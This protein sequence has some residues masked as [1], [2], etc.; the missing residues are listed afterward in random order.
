MEWI[1]ILGP[2]IHITKD[3][4][5]GRLGYDTYT[6]LEMYGAVFPKFEGARTE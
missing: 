1:N 6:Q 3:E 4:E 5:R 2:V